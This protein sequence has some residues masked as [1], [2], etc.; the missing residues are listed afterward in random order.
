MLPAA[1]AA[2]PPD[3][4]RSRLLRSSD[5]TPL[6]EL[7]SSNRKLWPDLEPLTNDSCLPRPSTIDLAKL[8]GDPLRGAPLFC[9]E[10]GIVRVSFRTTAKECRTIG[11]IEPRSDAQALHKIGIS[12]VKPTERNQVCEIALARVQGEWQ[13]VAIV[14]DIEPLECP[15]Q[16]LKIESIWNFTRSLG[17]SFDDVDVSQTKAIQVVHD[18]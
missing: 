11:Y 1:S 18:I 8:A 5:F 7:W 13:I 6:L 15:P 9:R 2:T 17:R 16:D 3:T 12:N 14:A 10:E 4:S